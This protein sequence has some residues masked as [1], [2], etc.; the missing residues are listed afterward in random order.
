MDQEISPATNLYL[1]LEF[2][3]IYIRVS[4]YYRI[5]S[6]DRGIIKDSQPSLVFVKVSWDMIMVGVTGLDGL[7]HVESSQ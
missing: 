3:D 7:C 6:L 2:L 4:Q 5:R 1:L